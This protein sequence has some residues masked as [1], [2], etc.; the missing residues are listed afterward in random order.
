MIDKFE[1]ANQEVE[2]SIIEHK[3]TLQQ[4]EAS[5]RNLFES[6]PDAV[7]VVCNDAVIDCNPAAVTMF[8][9]NNRKDL[10][11]LHPGQLSPNVQ[12]DGEESRVAVDLKI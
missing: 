3:K 9:V 1:S 2:R 10:L 7:L 6:S 8:G 11:A 4:A 5:H 12:L